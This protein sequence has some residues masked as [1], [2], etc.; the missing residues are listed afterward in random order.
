LARSTAFRL[1]SFPS[2]AKRGE[3]GEGLL[4][5]FF[6]SSLPGLKKD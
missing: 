6:A 2:V 1:D 4:L 5:A 3:V